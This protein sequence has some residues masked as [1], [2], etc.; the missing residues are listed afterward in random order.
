MKF[1]KLEALGNDFILIDGRA[2]APL[3]TAATLAALAD[4]R[5][6]IG[7]DQALLLRA[8]D[9]DNVAAVRIFNADGS[10]AEQC[11]NGMRA[12]AAWFDARAELAT[13]LRL[14]TPAG[15]VMISAAAQGIYAAEL[16]GQRPPDQDLVQR[17]PPKID[18]PGSLVGLLSIGNP[19]LVFAWPQPPTAED[20]ARV[21]ARISSDPRWRDR[22]NI[23]LASS[24]EDGTH[25]QLR[26][27]E[28]GVGPTPAC[29]SGACA[30]ALLL[31]RSGSEVQVDQPG[32]SL[33]IDWN[34][35]RNRVQTR[36]PARLVYHGSSA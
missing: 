18:P 8:S 19:H 9:R 13:E 11:G 24:S 23:G 1:A 16:P 17:A 12:I 28:R 4:R 21:A 22:V 36:G 26:V 15:P 5:L 25:I 10:E 33:V 20:L 3:P 29:G 2:G 35:D 32:G 6:G 14:A 31:G 34:K 30:A 7:F 27:H